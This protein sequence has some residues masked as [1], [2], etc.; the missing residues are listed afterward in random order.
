M[1][2][3]PKTVHPDVITELLGIKPSSTSVAGKKNIL[4]EPI[5]NGWFLCTRGKIKSKD[6]RRHI[7]WILDKIEPVIEE[8]RALQKEGATIDIMCFWGSAAGNGGPTIS[9]GQ[10]R[11]LVKLDLEV[12]WDVYFEGKDEDDARDDV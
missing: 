11:R 1:R 5:L 7:D 4:G 2:I 8:V 6:S 9:P 12:W 10:M 3:Y